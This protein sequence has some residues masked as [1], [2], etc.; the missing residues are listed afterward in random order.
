MPGFIE[1]VVLQFLETLHV[2]KVGIIKP[3]DGDDH[4]VPGFF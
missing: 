2:G 3:H 1:L 4:R